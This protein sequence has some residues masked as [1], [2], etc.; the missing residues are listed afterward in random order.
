MTLQSRTTFFTIRPVGYLRL[1]PHLKCE[2]PRISKDFDGN[3]LLSVLFDYWYKKNY[4]E[5]CSIS[6]F[7]ECAKMNLT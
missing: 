2:Q 4:F 3:E 6:L 5:M 7:A 1:T